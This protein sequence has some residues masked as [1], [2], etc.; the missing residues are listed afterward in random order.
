MNVLNNLKYIGKV[1][2]IFAKVKATH[3]PQGQ[4]SHAVRQAIR[5]EVSRL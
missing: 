2:L 1:C 4:G 3:S 5:Q